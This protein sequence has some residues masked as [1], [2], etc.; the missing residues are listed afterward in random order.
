MDSRI[1]R[2]GTHLSCYAY[3]DQVLEP[4]LLRLRWGPA[5]VLA[6]VTSYADLGRSEMDAGQ[7]C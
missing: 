5:I 2:R 6:A 1:Q 3:N 7:F 4:L